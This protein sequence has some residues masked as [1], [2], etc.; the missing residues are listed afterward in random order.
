MRF[1]HNKKRNTAFLYEALIRE[2]TKGT[3]QE[4]AAKKDIVVEIIKK[5]FNKGTAL[6]KELSLYKVLYSEGSIKKGKAEKLV[7]EVR[8]S[9]NKLNMQQIYDSQSALI[10]EV[11]R[12]LAKDVFSNF[13]PNYKNLASIQ[14]YLNYDMSPKKTGHTRR[15]NSRKYFCSV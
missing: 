2:L 3:I 11:N 5:Y 4:D 9:Y 1:K 8:E 15:S 13:V 10:K 12:R 14:Q 7:R 6:A